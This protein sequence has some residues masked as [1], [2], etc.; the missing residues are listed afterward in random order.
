MQSK[1]SK[2]RE[3]KV[4]DLVYHVLYGKVWI[5]ILLDIVDIYGYNENEKNRNHRELAVVQ[6]LPNTAHEFFFK[7]MVSKKNKISDTSGLVST[8]WLFKLELTKKS[9]SDEIV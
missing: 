2:I 6:M 1:K 7:K 5:G 8:N 4:G 9:E 3:L